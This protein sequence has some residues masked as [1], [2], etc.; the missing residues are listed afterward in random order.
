MAQFQAKWAQCR[1][2]SR[3]GPVMRATQQQTDC[4]W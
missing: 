3:R 1:K 4:E 2:E